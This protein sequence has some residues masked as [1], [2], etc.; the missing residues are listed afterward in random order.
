[1][2]RFLK[3]SWWVH[4]P[5]LLA[6]A[7]ML[8]LMLAQRPWPMR[9]PVHFN[10]FWKSDRWGSPWD[11]SMFP[12]LAIGISLSSIWSSAM[13]SKHEKGRKRF[14]LTLPLMVTPLGALAG[15]HSWY[16][17]NLP[18]LAQTGYAPGGWWWAAICAVILCAA[19]VTLEIFRKPIPDPDEDESG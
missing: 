18:E 2:F 19:S 1:M 3:S 17:W 15:V 5:G 13:W 8:S 12:I 11:F 7:A 10:F 16:W 6:V 14:N 4:L 9:A